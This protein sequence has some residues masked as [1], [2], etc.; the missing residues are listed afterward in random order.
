MQH[1][2]NPNDKKSTQGIEAK[3]ESKLPQTPSPTPSDD[4]KLTLND[5]DKAQ[6]LMYTWNTEYQFAKSIQTYRLLRS[7]IPKDHYIH[8]IALDAFMAFGYMKESKEC[9]SM[10]NNAFHTY[11]RLCTLSLYDTE[12]SPKSISEQHKQFG[13][14][15]TDH[16]APPK[17]L[18]VNLNRDPNRRLKIGILSS[19]VRTGHVVM[20]FSTPLFIRDPN[21]Y[22]LTV[23]DVSNQDQNAINSLTNK[24]I[25][26][27]NA[28]QFN[29]QW[30]AKKIRD[31]KI[32][33]LFEVS[34]LIAPKLD[35]RMG[36]L[37][38]HPAPIQIAYIGYPNTT[39]LDAMDFR[40]VD[41]VTDPVGSTD[42]FYTEKLLRFDKGVP[43]LS[44]TPPSSDYEK[45]EVI[46]Q[47]PS[48]TNSFYS[49]GIFNNPRKFSD[50]FLLDLGEVLKKSDS[51]LVFQYIN[52][53]NY[54]DNQNLFLDRFSFLTK[55]PINQ[56]REKIIF[57]P[58]LVTKERLELISKMDVAIDTYPYNGTTTDFDCLW[59]CAPIVTHTLPN[60][61]EANVTA[62]VLSHLN[63]K[64]CITSNSNDF[65]NTIIKVA[66]DKKFR[67]DLRKNAFLR[68]KLVLSR[69]CDHQLHSTQIWEMVRNEWKNYCAQPAPVIDP[70]Q[71]SS[72]P[73]LVDAFDIE[74]KDIKDV[75]DTAL[76]QETA[77]T[78]AVDTANKATPMDEKT[79]IDN[80]GLF[81]KKTQRAP[82]DAEDTLEEQERKVRSQTPDGK[83]G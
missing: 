13:T 22:E 23:Y 11:D 65:V 25:S 52:F 69:L 40:L 34:G 47:L 12:A 83:S 78:S 77:T 7:F 42:P 53:W 44:Y 36:A 51:K 8:Y 38:S 37:A 4:S 49:F 79:N 41:H 9:L 5:L 76:T 27:V 6:R 28:S 70:S 62:S 75:N 39:G 17:M 26:V 61:H 68:K 64:G 66:E 57:H 56:L 3:T 45:A 72:I 29:A 21:A 33:V 35:V 43:F 80:F 63:M 81:A 2:N 1:A 58:N 20:Q 50:A 71:A 74:C 55:I 82:M 48:E 15:I 67:S 32:D 16:L 46:Q 24:N 30:L 14:F 18:H 31:D 10:I 60:R 59:G 73:D 19:D 54:A